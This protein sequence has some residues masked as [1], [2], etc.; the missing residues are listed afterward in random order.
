MKMLWIG[1]IFLV[2]SSTGLAFEDFGPG[3]IHINV[4]GLVCDFCVRNIEKIFSRQEEIKDIQVNLGQRRVSLVLEPDSQISDEKI[5]D[6]VRSAG[7]NVVEII[8][9]PKDETR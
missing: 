9:R 2:L 5:N 8:R 7:Y 4:Q 1:L 6:L 3:D